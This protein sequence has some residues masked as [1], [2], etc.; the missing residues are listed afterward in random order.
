MS[1]P[2]GSIIIGCSL[3]SR[4]EGIKSKNFAKRQTNILCVRFVLFEFEF[5]IL[6]GENDEIDERTAFFVLRLSFN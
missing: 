4:R 5:G 2:G 3:P 6:T 1:N